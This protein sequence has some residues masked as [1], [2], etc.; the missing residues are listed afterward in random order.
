[1]NVKMDIEDD[2]DI[3]ELLHRWRKDC[4]NFSNSHSDYQ[5]SYAKKGKILAFISIFFSSAV[6]LSSFVVNSPWVSIF[7]GSLSLFSA[8]LQSLSKYLRYESKETKHQNLSVRYYILANEILFEISK[9]SNE[10]SLKSFVS[11]VKN[12]MESFLKE[13]PSGILKIKEKS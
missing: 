4:I 1:M 10:E 2:L 6:G 13:S 8:L 7:L 3:V 9:H 12:K 5:R 11:K